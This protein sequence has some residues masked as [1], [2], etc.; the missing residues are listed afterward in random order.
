[1]K[2]SHIYTGPLLTISFNT[3]ISRSF[4]RREKRS[5]FDMI[6]NIVDQ[7]QN[8]YSKSNKHSIVLSKVMDDNKGIK[9]Q[10]LKNMFLRARHEGTQEA[11]RN[12]I[13]KE[14]MKKQYLVESH[15]QNKSRLY[16][17]NKENIIVNFS[18]LTKMS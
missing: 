10:D 6:T 14:E 5:V 16:K 11:K 7:N 18:F 8:K 2:I 9:Y 3:V 4:I 13:R 17:Q 12:N 15:K 1:M